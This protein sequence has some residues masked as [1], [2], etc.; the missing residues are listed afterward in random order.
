MHEACNGTSNACF[1]HPKRLVMH[2]CYATSKECMLACHHH[3]DRLSCH[4]H[5]FLHMSSMR[6]MLCGEGVLGMPT[7][8]AL[9]CPQSLPSCL[10]PQSF[11]VP[12]HFVCVLV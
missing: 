5:G 3:R 9:A 11:Q 4:D 2:A 6:T 10:R 12:S 7:I 1:M 8:L